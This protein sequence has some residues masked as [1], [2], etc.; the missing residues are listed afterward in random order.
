MSNIIVII[1]L[2]IV[3]GAAVGYIVHQKRSGARCIGCPHAKNCKENGCNCIP[4]EE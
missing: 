3:L 4:E 1:I 2:L